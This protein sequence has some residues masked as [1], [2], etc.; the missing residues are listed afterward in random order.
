LMATDNF[1][2]IETMSFDLVRDQKTRVVHV[3]ESFL[4]IDVKFGIANLIDTLA[5]LRQFKH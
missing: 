2:P 4:T 1:D 3:K 5:L